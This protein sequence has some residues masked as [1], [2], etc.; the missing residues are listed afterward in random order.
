MDG[1]ILGAQ[2]FVWWFGIVENRIDP[3]ELGRCRVRCFGWHTQNK[4]QIQTED[5]PWAH[6]VVPYGVKSV[7]PPAEG[8]MV[9]GFFA[10]GKEGQ[11]P[12]LMG[13]VPGIPEEILDR[14]TGFSDPLSAADKR[15]AAMPRKID[16]GASQLGKDTKGIR[17]ADEDPSRY[18][19]YLNEPTISRLA[20]PVR[21]E[22]DGKFDGVT[23]ESIANT[24]IDIQRKTRVTGIPTAAAS[25]WDEAYPS[26]AAKFPYNNVTETESGHAF[27]L[28]DT[29]GFERVQLSHRTGSTLEFAN[30]GATKIKSTSSRQDITMGDQRTYVNGDKYETIDGDYYLQIGGKLRILAKSVEIVSGS[31]TAISAPQGISITGGQ[32]VAITGLSASMSGVSTTVSGVKTQVSGEMSTTVSGAVTHILGNAAVVV[33]SPY[34]R[35]EH[36]I[37]EEQGIKNLN[38]CTPNPIP[39]PLPNGPP[40]PSPVASLDFPAPNINF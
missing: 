5:L 10:D 22:K 18:P 40:P 2:G 34:G 27:E 36:L 9:F 29:F 11:Y 13:T 28:D 3:L 15:N 7:Q 25:Q 38:T 30:T 33:K 26:Y 21:G 16:T 6:P 31:G 24:T 35:A 37:S 8:T 20:R 32:S 17:I 4:S 23:N 19:K 14:S 1:A 12:I 39:D